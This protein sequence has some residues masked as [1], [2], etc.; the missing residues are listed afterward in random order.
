VIVP[1]ERGR[2]S[3][4]LTNE[5]NRCLDRFCE[6]AHV[7]SIFLEALFYHNAIIF[8]RHGFRY[9]EGEKRMR[10]IHEAF[11]VGGDLHKRLDGSTP[12]R[13]PGFETTVRGRSWA[14]Y[15]GILDGISD[16]GIGDGWG[17]PKMYRMTGKYY[18]VD[19]FPGG[20]Y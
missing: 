2:R 20:H 9:L 14:I 3:L 11:R 19:T 10:R 4:R 17:S 8:E 6:L 18:R 16:E 13:Q 7:K 15:D 1:F 5:V 12:F